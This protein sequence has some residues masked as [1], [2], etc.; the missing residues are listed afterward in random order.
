[1][2]CDRIQLYNQTIGNVGNVRLRVISVVSTLVSKPI[3]TYC[4]SGVYEL[5]FPIYDAHKI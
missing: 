2:H 5:Q 4:V 3:H 1:M